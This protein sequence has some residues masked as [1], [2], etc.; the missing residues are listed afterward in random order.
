MNIRPIRFVFT[1][2]VVPIFTLLSAELDEIE[3]RMDQLLERL[4]KMEPSN[5]SQPV[6]A[7]PNGLDLSSSDQDKL[8]SIPPSPLPSH[9]KSSS[10]LKHL[11]FLIN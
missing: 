4:N 3:S 10:K 2:L 9:N 7:P 11:K 6:E 8:P 1:L 5:S